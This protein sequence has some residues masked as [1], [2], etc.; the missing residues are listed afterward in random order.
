[1]PGYISAMIDKSVLQSLS[2]REAKWLFHHLKVNI[3]PILFSEVLADLEKTK[4]VLA[5]G[6][7]VGDVRM[8]ANKIVSHSVFLNAAHHDLIASELAGHPV[9][10][11]GRPVVGNA[12]SAR[13]PDGSIG[14]L[15]DQTPFQAVMDRWCA[16]DFDGMEREFA[17]LWRADQARIDL[18]ALMR[19]TKYLRMNDLSD[20]DS[21]IN[22]VHGILFNQWPNYSHLD[23]I[24]L[25]AGADPSSRATAL[26]RWNRAR[27]PAPFLFIPYTSFVARLEAIFMFGLHAKL[28]TTRA[29]NRLDIE[30]FKYL[31]FTDVFSSG[32]KLHATLFRAFANRTQTF[33]TGANLKASLRAMADYYDSLSEEE[34]RH[35]SMSYADY[36][37][38][39][40]DNAIT[41]LFDQR[42]PNWRKGAN[43]PRPPRDT[44]GDAELL[45]ELKSRFEWLSRNAK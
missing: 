26:R 44:S 45:A 34:L 1:M 8:L 10:M 19:E 43:L 22:H 42:F 39:S 28:V 25:L 35:G 5:T 16:G 38:V 11:T 30:Y 7:G 14:L 27:R 3:P 29:T 33:V 9:E 12:K 15:V 41:K 31:P 20:L 32:D 18:E 23:N 17:R 40:M 24:M 37:P 36:P 2:A 6:S 13:M 21:V 4:G